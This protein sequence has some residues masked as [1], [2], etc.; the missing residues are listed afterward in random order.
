M[1]RIVDLRAY[2]VASGQGDYHAQGPD[3][4]LVASPIATPMS[5][6]FT[7]GASLTPSPVIATIALRRFHA[8]TTCSLCSAETRA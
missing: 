2:V 8:R 5:A 7:A 1:A 6:S 3:H 4:W